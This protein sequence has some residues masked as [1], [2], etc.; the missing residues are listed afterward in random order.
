MVKQVITLPTP[1]GAIMHLTKISSLWLLINF[2]LI[3]KFRAVSKKPDTKP[4]NSTLWNST[5]WNSTAD[6]TVEF[7]RVEFHRVEFHTAVEYVSNSQY[8]FF[9]IYF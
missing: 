5:V 6:T 7:H 8:V 4:W 3:V 1:V 2:D 9:L